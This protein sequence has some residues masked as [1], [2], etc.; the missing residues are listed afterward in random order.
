MKRS[1]ISAD[2]HRP[3]LTSPNSVMTICYDIISLNAVYVPSFRNLF[4]PT[5]F[6]LNAVVF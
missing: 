3:T 6:F 4:V 2:A 5:L 1:E